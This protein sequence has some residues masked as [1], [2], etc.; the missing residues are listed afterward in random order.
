MKND[1]KSREY[2]KFRNKPEG[3][4][5]VATVIENDTPI[6]VSTAGIDWNKI[7]TTFPAQNQEIYTYKKDGNIVQTVTI[8]YEDGTK[9]TI[10]D[11][12]KVR[13]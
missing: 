12:S 2:E 6:N 5:S 4:T 7:E 3:Q 13:V 8:T 9:K 11:V 10:I 1:L